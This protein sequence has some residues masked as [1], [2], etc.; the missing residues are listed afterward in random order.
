MLVCFCQRT[1]PLQ[2]CQIRSLSARLGS[3]QFNSTVHIS[4]YKTRTDESSGMLLPYNI[5]R[6]EQDNVATIFRKHKAE[7]FCYTLPR[8]CGA[9]QCCYTLPMKCGAAQ[10]CYTLHR[11]CGAA[12]CCYTLPRKCGAAQCCYP[13]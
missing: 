2:H 5:G 8:K 12:Q 1:T 4:V 10:C 11:K 3:Q 13:V 6:M 7:Q 9:A